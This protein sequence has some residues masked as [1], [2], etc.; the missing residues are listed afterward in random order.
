MLP[1]NPSPCSPTKFT[2]EIR[3]SGRTT[4]HGGG[5]RRVDTTHSRILGTLQGWVQLWQITVHR[6]NLV[7]IQ[8]TWWQLLPPAAGGLNLRYMILGK[9]LKVGKGLGSSQR[10]A[11]RG[12]CCQWRGGGFYVVQTLVRG[13]FPQLHLKV[14]GAGVA[15]SITLGGIATW[16]VKEIS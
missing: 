6:I 13:G 9:D 15:A 11:G 16:K 12:L 10:L 5:S 14:G 3:M 1:L 7:E 8:W 2:K 4:G